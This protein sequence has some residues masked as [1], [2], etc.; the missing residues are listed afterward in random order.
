MLR[1]I[2]AYKTNFYMKNWITFSVYVIFTNCSALIKQNT[3]IMEYI[4]SLELG[5]DKSQ[6]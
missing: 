5:L 3:L 4:Q 6:H 1:A 2:L